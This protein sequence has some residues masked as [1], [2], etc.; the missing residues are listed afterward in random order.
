MLAAAA[1]AML[2]GIGFATLQPSLTLIALDRLD[3]RRRQAGTGLFVACM[4]LGVAAGTALAG[5]VADW[6]GE[7]A[8]P[9]PAAGSTIAGAG[10]VAEGLAFGGDGS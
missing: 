3:P 6:Q 1:G 10:V 5:V 4:D 9:L 8:A 7:Q 2:S